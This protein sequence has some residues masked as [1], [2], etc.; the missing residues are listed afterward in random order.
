MWIE[1][2]E[3][4]EKG[5][6]HL[7]STFLILRVWWFYHREAIYYVATCAAINI[8]KIGFTYL[9]SSKKV[10]LLL[11]THSWLYHFLSIVELEAFSLY[12]WSGSTTAAI[13]IL[14]KRYTNMIS[15]Q[16]LFDFNQRIVKEASSGSVIIWSLS[17]HSHWKLKMRN[18]LK[19]SSFE[20]PPTGYQNTFCGGGGG[21][22]SK[23]GLFCALYQR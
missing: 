22:K 2:S 4:H 13:Q 18:I 1:F 11:W 6:L 19:N 15:F 8:V 9:G 16:D 12:S 10:T 20:N 23:F 17:D 14:G 3:L 7:P 21:T 5:D